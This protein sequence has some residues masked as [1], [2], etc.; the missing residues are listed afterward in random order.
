M[1]MLVPFEL[2]EKDRKAIALFY[3]EKGLSDEGICTLWITMA[4]EAALDDVLEKLDEHERK[5]GMKARPKRK[6]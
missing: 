2:D 3:K 4:V 1:K 5:K 6:R